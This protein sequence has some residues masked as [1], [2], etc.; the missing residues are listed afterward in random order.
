MQTHNPFTGKTLRCFYDPVANKWWFSA[1]DI[2]AMLTGHEHEAARLSWHRYKHEL[3]KRKGQPIRKSYRLKMPS[4]NG[5]YYFTDVLDTK[6]AI[7]LM[8]ITPNPAA[9]PFRRWIAEVVANNT[10]MEALL[11]EPGVENARQIVEHVKSTNK[12]YE[13]QMVTR[14]KLWR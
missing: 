12:P 4:P 2:Y 10:A 1:I 6:E 9:E 8:Q 14:E 5:K 11:V 3:A 7:Y 13:L